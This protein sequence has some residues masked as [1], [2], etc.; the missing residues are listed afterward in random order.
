MPDSVND[1]GVCRTDLATLGLLS[2]RYVKQS[3]CII[4]V[5]PLCVS[6][7]FPYISPFIPPCVPPYQLLTHD[8]HSTKVSRQ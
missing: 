2:D 7:Y 8:R 5:F 6:V 4:F 3:L 1:K